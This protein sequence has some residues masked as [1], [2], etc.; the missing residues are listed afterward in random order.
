MLNME[1][2]KGFN[3]YSLAVSL[4]LTLQLRMVYKKKRDY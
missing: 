1:R 4:Q 3:P 2:N